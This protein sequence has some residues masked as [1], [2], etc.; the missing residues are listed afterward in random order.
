[1][2][3][4]FARPKIDMKNIRNQ[5]AAWKMCFWI[6]W[7]LQWK[8]VNIC[9]LSRWQ[10]QRKRNWNTFFQLQSRFAISD[11]AMDE[12][13]KAFISYLIKIIYFQRLQHNSEKTL[14][15]CTEIHFYNFIFSSAIFWFMN[16][17]LM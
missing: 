10:M 14:T 12:A 16:N 5:V 4:M 11:Q 1:V 8:A 2:A 7:L 17:N 15:C 9:C 6:G 3:Q 13:F